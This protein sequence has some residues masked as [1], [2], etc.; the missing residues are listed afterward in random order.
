M[1]LKREYGAE[2]PFWKLGPFKVRL[3]LVHYRFEGADYLQ[4]LIMCAVCLS[5]IPLL[6]ETLG[7]PFEVALAI[8]VLNG[9]LYC[10]HVL[11]GDPVVP[12][13]ITPAI[14]LLAA[15]VT[16]FEPGVPRIHALAAFEITLGVFVIFLGATGLAQKFIRYV[17]NAI[18]SGVILG[19]GFAAVM[20]IFKEGGR[21]EKYPYTITIAVGIAFL[22]LFSKGFAALRQKSKFWNRFSDLGILPVILLGIVIAPIFGEASWPEIQWGISRPDFITLFKEYTPWGVGWPSVSMFIKA[23]PMV[24]AVYIVLFGDVIQSQALVADANMVREDEYIDYNPNRA[25]M[26]FGLRNSLMGMFGPDISMCGPLWA[27]MQVVV[28]ERYKHGREAM[29][30]LFSGAGWFRF[31]TLTGYLLL[32]IVTLTKPTLGVALALTMLIQGYVS[33]RIAVEKSFNQRDIGIAGVMGAVLATKGAAWGF[34]A[35]IVLTLL[36]YGKDFFK[37]TSVLE[38][39]RPYMGVPTPASE[40]TAVTE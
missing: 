32:P 37:D 17:P 3:P 7:M 30:S 1:A 14:P 6:Q 36:I 27:A 26:I 40:Q 22:I 35:G 24:L 29:D 33:V 10:L 11:L 16:S 20:M 4:G 38:G 18:K 5:I 2:Q 25:H 9:I 31:G 13:W 19:A 15:Y 34:A 12:G 39:A 23:I 21:F 8:V 28:C